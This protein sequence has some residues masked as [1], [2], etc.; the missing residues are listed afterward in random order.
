MNKRRR[1]A[2]VGYAH[3]HRPEE[4]MGEIVQR[5]IFVWAPDPRAPRIGGCGLP[6]LWSPS[7]PHCFLRLQVTFPEVV[8][9]YGDPFSSSKNR[10]WRLVGL[11]PPQSS[12]EGE[13]R[14]R[15]WELIA[16]GL[17][18]SGPIWDPDSGL[19]TLISAPLCVCVPHERHSLGFLGGGVVSPPQ[20]KT[21]SG[22]LNELRTKVK[23]IF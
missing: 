21:R 20:A 3:W 12:L 4:W 19:L 1:W 5:K 17:P 18:K 13:P 22:K 16:C 14:W 7:P 9:P 6:H 2:W 23:Y 8:T 10:F 11:P 15:C